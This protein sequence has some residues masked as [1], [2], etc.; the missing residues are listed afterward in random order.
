MEMLFRVAVMLGLLMGALPL[1]AQDGAMG[2]VTD[3]CQVPVD[4]SAGAS[5]DRAELLA[6]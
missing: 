3:D 2:I 6:F 1:R 5:G 4:P